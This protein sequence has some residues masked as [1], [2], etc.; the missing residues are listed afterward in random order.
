[1]ACLVDAGLMV[2]GV[3]PRVDPAEVEECIHSDARGS[4]VAVIGHVRAA[5]QGSGPERREPLENS[6]AYRVLSSFEKRSI[7]CATCQ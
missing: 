1:M 3:A 2:V 7:K 6:F 5:G 4:P